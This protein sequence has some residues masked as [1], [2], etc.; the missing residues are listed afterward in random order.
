MIDDIYCIYVWVGDILTFYLSWKK[1]KE[2][3]MLK[4]AGKLKLRIAMDEGKN[5]REEDI[6]TLSVLYAQICAPNLNK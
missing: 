4:N 2:V 3:N 1:N 6:Y 5:P